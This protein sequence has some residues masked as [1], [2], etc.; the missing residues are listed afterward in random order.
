MPLTPRLLVSKGTEA[1]LSSTSPIDK[2]SCFTQ[3]SEEKIAKTLGPSPIYPAWT[4]LAR[5]LKTYLW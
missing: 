1:F 3:P 4:H 2:R 5:R